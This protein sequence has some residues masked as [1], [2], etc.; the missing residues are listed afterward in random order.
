M[1]AAGGASLRAIAQEAGR[2]HGVAVL[3]LAVRT[4]LRRPADGPIQAS[5]DNWSSLS[6]RA[7]VRAPLPPERSGANAA[8]PKHAG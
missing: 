2:R 6:F 4:A 5:Y 1:T 7:L 8:G 3:H